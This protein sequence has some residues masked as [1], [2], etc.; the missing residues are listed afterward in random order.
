VAGEA[1]LVVWRLTGMAVTLQ[2]KGRDTVLESCVPLTMVLAVPFVMILALALAGR[3]AHWP[4]WTSGGEAGGHRQAVRLSGCQAGGR[5]VRI[6]SMPPGS[7][8]ARAV[9]G[10]PVVSA[11]IRDPVPGFSRLGVQSAGRGRARP[12]LD[13]RREDV[14]VSGLRDFLSVA[15]ESGG[16]RPITL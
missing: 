14:G 15:V 7:R 10:M 11:V 6:G 9:A 2:L 3:G 1:E 8:M 12:R 4:G 16:L 13:Q 5:V